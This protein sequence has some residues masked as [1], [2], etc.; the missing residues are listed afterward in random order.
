V[1]ER[2]TS[3]SVPNSEPIDEQTERDL[4]AL[5]DGS[6]DPARREQV[7][8][9]VAESPQLQALLREQ[10]G[11]LAA[12]VRDDKAPAGLRKRVESERPRW[13]RRARLRLSLVPAAIAVVALAVIL[14]APEGA[15]ERA[16]V[17]SAATLSERAPTD[18]PPPISERSWRLLDMETQGVHYPNWERR[19]GWRAIGSRADRL[20]GRSAR[21]LFYEK[22]GRRIGYT[23]LSGTP[24]PYPRESRR[25][26]RWGTRLRSTRVDDLAVVTWR[27]KGRTCVLAGKDVTASE[28]V[29]LGAWR[30]Y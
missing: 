12:I 19:F 4:A 26:E 30:M 16:S 3:M 13:R 6:L 10:R 17:A 23:V 8:A 24:L 22:D 9:R 27:R 20:G 21:T 28:M 25:V 5:A 29:D 11:A 1:P 7:E 14:V 15:G 2:Q 18:P